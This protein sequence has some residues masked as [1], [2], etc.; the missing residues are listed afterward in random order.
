MKTRRKS[1]L[2]DLKILRE[3]EFGA[4]KIQET[5][6]NKSRA[7]PKQGADGLIEECSSRSMRKKASDGITCLE[8]HLEQI[9]TLLEHL[10]LTE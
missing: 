4:N 2:F 10:N 5:L 6:L 9:D 3:S 8:D 7:F 1:W